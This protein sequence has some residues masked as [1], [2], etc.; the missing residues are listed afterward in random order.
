M[1]EAEIK[2]VLVEALKVVDDC[3][4]ATGHFRVA[5]TSI[6][7]MKIERAINALA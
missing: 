1:T 6:Q 7:R 4:T 5:K 2:D 3:Y